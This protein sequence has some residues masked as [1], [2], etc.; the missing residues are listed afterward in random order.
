MIEKVIELIGENNYIFNSLN[1]IINNVVIKT[2]LS[3]LLVI[4]LMLKLSESIFKA[5]K[6]IIESYMYIKITSKKK[7]NNK[8]IYQEPNRG[9]KNK[10]GKRDRR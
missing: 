3:I 4:Y 5:L 9:Y 6:S 10:R 2:I 1:S 7:A 8:R